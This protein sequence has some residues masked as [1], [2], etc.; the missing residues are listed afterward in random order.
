MLKINKIILMIALVILVMCASSNYEVKGAG[1]DC[2]V[3]ISANKKSV[4]VGNTVVISIRITNITG[5]NGI[6]A[7]GGFVDYDK[8][9]LEYKSRNEI[10]DFEA[11]KIQDSN[12]KFLVKRSAKRI[13]NYRRDHSRI[14]IR[15]KKSWDSNNEVFRY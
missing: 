5:E 15:S 11:S 7:L 3:I 10:G 2:N 6:G 12:G 4:S 9:I 13:S 14:H 8:S 1:Y